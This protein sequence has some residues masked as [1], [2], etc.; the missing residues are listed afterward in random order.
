MKLLI[1]LHS[2]VQKAPE[3]ELSACRNNL[4]TNNNLCQQNMDQ[5]EVRG[6]PAQ[7]SLQVKCARGIRTRRKPP[8]QHSPPTAVTWPSLLP[9]CTL[10]E[11]ARSRLSWLQPKCQLQN[12]EASQVA[13][14]QSK[15]LKQQLVSVRFIADLKKIYS[16]LAILH[17]KLTRHIREISFT[18]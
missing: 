14:L 13:A 5:R 16:T 1:Y 7:M 10:K 4:W 15:V 8:V 2:F 3:I 17:L 12:T 6:R 9:P 11:A 18:V